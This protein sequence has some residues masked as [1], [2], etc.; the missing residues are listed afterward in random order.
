MTTS[1]TKQHSHFR[2][3][4]GLDLAHQEVFSQTCENSRVYAF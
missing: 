4:A 1:I 3:P 2:G